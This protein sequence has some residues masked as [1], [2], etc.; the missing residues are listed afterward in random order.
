MEHVDSGDTSSGLLMVVNS[1]ARRLRET[2]GDTS[3]GL[4]MV[5][6]ISMKSLKKENIR[7]LVISMKSLKK[8]NIRQLMLPSATGL[9][10]VMLSM[11][12]LKKE[13]IRQLMLPSA[14]GLMVVERTSSRPAFVMRNVC[15]ARSRCCVA[16]NVHPGVEKRLLAIGG[17]RP[18][19]P[20]RE[21]MKMPFTREEVKAP[22]VKRAGVSP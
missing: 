5:V 21:S 10:V 11:K 8:E 1:G 4:L 14:T 22:L 6:V 9:M 20:R 18:L 17:E 3:S 16:S 13:N 15:C 19:E 2:K 12:S 7:Q